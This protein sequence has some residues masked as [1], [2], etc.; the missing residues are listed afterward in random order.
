[1]FEEKRNQMVEKLIAF[2]YLK[3]PGVAEAMR[4]VPRH[5]F[6][7]ENLISYAYEDTP[8]PVGEEQT[9]SAPHMVALMCD[10]L[11]LEEEHIVLE[12]GAG[13]GYHACVVAEIVKKGFVYSIERIEKLVERAKQNLENVGC[14]RV[15]IILGDGTKGYEKASPYDRIFVTAGAPKIPEPLIKQLKVNGRLLI[16]V[17]SRYTQELI[18]VDKLSEEKIEKKKLGG[19]AFVPLIGD[20]GW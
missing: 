7:P 9:I 20:Y 10:L 4:K 16:P 18:Q 15:K 13:T 12:I 1:M 19:C 17:G 6:V 3:D 14:K 2:G 11:D 8:L 5:L